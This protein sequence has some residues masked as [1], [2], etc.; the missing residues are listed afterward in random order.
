MKYRQEP[1]PQSHLIALALLSL[2][3]FFLA[4]HTAENIQQPRYRLKMKAAQSVVR[5]QDVIKEELNRRGLKL[6]KRND[7]WHSGLIGE[8][9]TVVTSDRGVS[10]A[11]IL[12]TNPNFAAAFVDL[13]YRSG[14][15]KGDT[16]A[17]GLTGSIPG[18]NVAFYA[19]CQAMGVTPIVITSVAASDWGANRPDL[20]WL[21][22][23]SL[24]QQHGVFDIKSVAASIGGGADIGRGI[25]PEGRDLLRSSISRNGVPLIEGETLESIIDARMKRYDSLISSGKYAA[26]VN[27]GGG[28]ASLGGAM[29]AKLIPAGFSRHLREINYPV[30]AVINRMGERD[31]PIVN[32][33]D[34]VKVAER[35]DLPTFIGA[36]LPEV[37]QGRLY[38]SEQYDITWTAVLTALL[39]LI[40]FSVIRLDLKHYLGRR[41][42]KLKERP[43]AI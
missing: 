40:I 32:L 9:R 3:V 1:V 41:P 29:N 27:I 12:A 38:F 13:L 18:W 20:S 8:E 2:I 39:G 4:E 24:L 31:V 22:M 10:T 34:V 30:R 5:A 25:S 16:V 28:L 6:D 26:Y 23:E 35:F 17:V 15:R 37:G 33:S 11:K 43:E 7:P 42:R 36:E 21:D 19:A 14:V